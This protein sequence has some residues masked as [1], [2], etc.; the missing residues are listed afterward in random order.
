M[1]LVYFAFFAILP[2]LQYNGHQAILFDISEQRFTLW[3]LTLWPQDLTL[4]AW[5]FIFSAFLTN[6]LHFLSAFSV[7]EQVLITKTSGASLKST[8]ANP[9]SSNIR[10]TVD[11]SEKL[12]LQPKVYNA[13]FLFGLILKLQS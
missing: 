3:G 5:L 4:L 9:S 10:A 13:T 6:C 11:V 1:N 7:T 8:R 2:W 12:S